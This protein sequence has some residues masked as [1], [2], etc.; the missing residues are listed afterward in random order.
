MKLQAAR[1]GAP[2]PPTKPEPAT[3]GTMNIALQVRP[4]GH[5]VMALDKV[6]DCLVMDQESALRLADAIQQ[7]IAQL[8]SKP[9]DEASH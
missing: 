8:N 4:D 3:G 1:L 2:K 9:D 6:T 7:T 5:L